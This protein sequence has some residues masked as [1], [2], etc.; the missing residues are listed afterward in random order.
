MKALITG[1]DGFI[2]SHLAD[3]LVEKGWEVWGTTLRGDL[4]NV[5]HL[6]NQLTVR[7]CDVR[8]RA[9]LKAVLRE[10]KPDVVFHLAAQSRPD[11]SWKDPYLTMEVNVLGTVNLF[12]SVREL[13]IEPKIVVA[14][15]SSQY[16]FL[17]KGKITEEHPFHPL[18]PY[19]VSKAAQDL[20]AYQYFQNY[21]MKTYRARIFG[22]TG[23]RKVGDACADFATQIVRIKAG[24]KEPVIRVGNLEA[25]R[26]LT[27]V[28]DTVRALWL[29]SERGREGEAYNICSSKAIRIGDILETM[30]EMAKIEA[31]IEVDP[32]KL[33]PSD[34]PIIVG[35]NAK[36]RKHCG[37]KPRIPMRKTLL[38]I[39][40]YWQS[41]L[42]KMF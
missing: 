23:P 30:L 35:S 21:G 10:S 11:L 18:S 12:E 8:E 41:C 34:E 20:M 15:S 38:D 24:K 19:A 36:I 1:V 31:K 42:V 29:I 37:W 26:D 39:L 32:A 9:R 22:T 13:G 16:G 27:D 6:K 14:C 2:G 40:E 28:R 17:K 33:R 4:D 5:A 3:L 25:K 7:R